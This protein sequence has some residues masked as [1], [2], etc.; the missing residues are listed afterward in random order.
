MTTRFNVRS[1]GLRSGYD[2][3]NY[4][5]E[6]SI[7]SCGIEDIDR[8]IFHLFNNEI[9]LQVNAKDG[10]KK[11]KV[12][13][14]SGEKWAVVKKKKEI[15][16][17]QGRLILPLITIGRTSVS[18]SSDDI[19]GRGINQQT[20]EL[21][22][23]R[24]LSNS[25]RSYQNLINRL[26]IK[27]QLNVAVN[28]ANGIEP[29]TGQLTTDRDIG[30]LTN[31]ADIADGGFLAPAKD[32]NIWETITI[33]APQFF[34]ARYEVTFWTQYIHHM[35]EL[36]ELFIAAQLPQG[37]AYRIANPAKNYWFVATIDNNEYT[38]ENNFDNMFE[39]ERIIKYSFTVTVPGYIL[40]TSVPGAPV[41]VR[42]YVSQTAID[43]QTDVGPIA[44]PGQVDEADPWLGADDPTLP[45]ENDLP[46]RHLG[47]DQR[48]TGHRRLDDRSAVNSNDPALRAFPR[49]TTPDRYMTV[50][51]INPDGS[52]GLRRIKIKN[53]NKFSGEST[54]S[55]ADLTLGGLTLV[56]D[57]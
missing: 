56:V 29:L 47:I 45:F 49:G 14:A 35:N 8:A 15:R 16:D 52:S 34:T 54:F 20:G 24:R 48:R 26:L 9:P 5:S 44:S 13:F 50:K 21:R 19:T 31:I 22:I 43:F 37:N 40:A 7:P 1:G 28:P 36:V 51:T 6:L 2:N 10:L 17:K 57:E 30:D 42:R 11:A 18:Q 41:P 33:P 46:K 3:T 25:D 55:A 38:P 39:Q 53:V 12:I 4:S 23:V 27:N 32:K